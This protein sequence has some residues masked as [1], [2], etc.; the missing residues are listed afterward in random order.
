MY[1]MSMIYAWNQERFSFA[2]FGFE[3]TQYKLS[4]AGESFSLVIELVKYVSASDRNALTLV[5]T[6]QNLDSTDLSSSLAKYFIF[7]FA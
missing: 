6:P 3:Q 1:V 4:G 2:V 5:I 7:H